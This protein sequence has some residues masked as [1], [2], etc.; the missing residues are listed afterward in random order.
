FTVSHADELHQTLLQS[1]EG[2]RFLEQVGEFLQEYGWRSVKSHDLI[3]ETWAE[4]PY[5]ALANI[6]N[7]VLRL[8]R[9]TGDR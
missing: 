6:Q 1:N 3:E 2:K 7:Y 4:N 9:H 8:P 5:F